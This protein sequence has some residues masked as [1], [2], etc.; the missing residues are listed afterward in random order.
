MTATIRRKVLRLYLV[1]PLYSNLT[2]AIKFRPS[3]VLLVIAIIFLYI[4]ILH[5]IYAVQ[6]YAR[7]KKASAVAAKQLSTSVHGLPRLLVSAAF[8]A[9]ILPFSI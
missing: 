2:T 7:S 5:N 8:L 4:I 9:W 6:A 3:A 1:Q